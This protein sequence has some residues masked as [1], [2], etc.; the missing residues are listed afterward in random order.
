MDMSGEGVPP[1]PSGPPG[2]KPPKREQEREAKR[3]ARE[4]YFAWR[5]IPLLA[6]WAALVS[7]IKII[8]FNGTPIAV[9]LTGYFA[10]AACCV[11]WLARRARRHTAKR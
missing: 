7:A 6:M 1:R 9:V 4:R 5:I 10:G 11:V 3:Q 2:R 8:A